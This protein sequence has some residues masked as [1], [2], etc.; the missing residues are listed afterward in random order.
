MEA[1]F[2]ISTNEQILIPAADPVLSE[3][4]RKLML[5]RFTIEFI[6]FVNQTFPLPFG[7]NYARA[8]EVYRTLYG[9]T[10][11]QV[12]EEDVAETLTYYLASPVNLLYLEAVSVNRKP[13]IERFTQIEYTRK[14]QKLKL[15][16]TDAEAFL[17]IA[18]NRIDDH[19]KTYFSQAALAE[20]QKK[21]YEDK[22]G[23]HCGIN[24]VTGKPGINA[25][26]SGVL[27]ELR[28]TTHGDGRFRRRTG[29]KHDGIDISCPIGTPIYSNQDGVV[30]QLTTGSGFGNRVILKHS[31]G[32]YTHYAHLTSFAPGIKVDN[33]RVKVTEGQLIGYSGRT[34]NAG[35]SQPHNEDHVHFGVS[36]SVRPTELS[37]DW[38]NPVRYLNEC[39][40]TTEKG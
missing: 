25:V 9:L 12:I 38:K 39:V 3:Y 22:D 29:G 34:G 8:A 33:S 5:T 19:L 15:T 26:S 18:D 14:N 28:L 21:P 35:G 27:G 4:G 17:K 11:I 16:R 23:K 2:D 7:E 30:E 13:F 32:I 6:K 37:S 31:G 1:R 40:L 24:P 10:I 20:L 36:T